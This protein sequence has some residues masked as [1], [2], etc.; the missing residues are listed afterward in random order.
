MGQ[1]RP[2]VLI[3]LGIALANDPAHTIVL[4][5]GAHRPI[6]DLAGTNVIRFDG[7][8][9]ALG[10]VVERLK[11]AGCPVN[12]VGADWRDEARFAGLAVYAR[13]VPSVERHDK[14]MN[15]LLPGAR[16]HGTLTSD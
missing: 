16:R 12:E 3:E 6:A 10:K 8:S 9:V 13:E 4:E 1:A 5:V 15:N 7:G 2:N 14:I 11:S